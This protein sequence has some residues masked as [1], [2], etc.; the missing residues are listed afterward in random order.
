[1]HSGEDSSMYKQL[2]QITKSSHNSLEDE[3][4]VI[5][6]DR[7]NFWDA[8]DVEIH[9]LENATQLESVVAQGPLRASVRAEVEYGDSRISVTIPA[10]T[11]L[12]SR[13]MFRFDAWVDWHQ[14]HEFLKFEL[15]LAISNDNAT[16]ETQ[17]GWVQRPTHKNT[18]WDMAKLEVCR[19]KC[20]GLS[21]YGYGVALLSESKYGFASQGPRKYP[22]DLVASPHRAQV[23]MGCHGH[24]LESDVPTA[25][26]LF[27]SPLYIRSVAPGVSART[28]KTGH[29][30]FDIE[31]APDVF[32]ETV[33][34]REDDSFKSGGK[35]TVVLRLY[36]AFGGHAQAQLHIAGG[37]ARTVVLVLGSVSKK[38]KVKAE[39]RESWD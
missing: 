27:N 34:R 7:P 28:L 38:E 6:E 30:P 32:L 36:E 25:A 5:L 4:L 35:T 14:R 23:L 3:A 9:H 19:H 31:G 24:F 12:D 26:Y 39:K 33:K 11:K 17:F 20:A 8:R 16:Y 2:H 29:S 22:P 1:M 18:T 37:R 10:S 13:G 15:P 21:E